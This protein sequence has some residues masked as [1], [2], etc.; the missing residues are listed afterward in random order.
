MVTSV[1][2]K[3]PVWTHKMLQ[4]NVITDP[5]NSNTQCSIIFTVVNTQKFVSLSDLA[6]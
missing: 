4:G 1:T 6:L 2:Q 3:K 5:D